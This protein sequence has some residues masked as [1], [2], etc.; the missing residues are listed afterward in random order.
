MAMPISQGNGGIREIMQVWCTQSVR[1]HSVVAIVVIKVGRG[2]KQKSVFSS[3]LGEHFLTC[4]L[5]VAFGDNAFI[6]LISNV[7]I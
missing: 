5:L 6:I 7:M 2:K 3:P 4:K 1:A